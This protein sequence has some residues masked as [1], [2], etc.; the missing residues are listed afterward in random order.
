MG[1]T[2]KS[3]QNN[4]PRCVKFRPQTVENSVLREAWT[5]NSIRTNTSIIEE[6]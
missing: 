6:K 3:P 2:D 5:I 4:F 1:I